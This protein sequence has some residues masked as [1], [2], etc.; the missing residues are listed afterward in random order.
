MNMIIYEDY[1][2]RKAGLRK[3]GKMEVAKKMLDGGLSV[4]DVSKYT[5]LSLDEIKNIP[6]NKKTD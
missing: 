6:A 4:E 3:E 1:E 5:G 2:K